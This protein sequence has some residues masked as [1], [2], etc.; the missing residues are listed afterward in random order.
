MRVT[1]LRV[2]GFLEMGKY[3]KIFFGIAWRAV[4]VTPMIMYCF[5][6][7]C[8]IIVPPVL[9]VITAVI[10]APPITRLFSEPA[11]SLFMPDEHF[12]RKQP[13]YSIPESKKVKGFY[14][15]A[16]AGY[17]KIAD[18]YP[19]ESKPYIEIISILAF[20]LNDMNRAT[21]VY[22][23]GL[24]KLT[25]SKQR[26]ALSTF[27]RHLKN[28][29]KGVTAEMRGPALLTKDG[30]RIKRAIEPFKPR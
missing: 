20:S 15:E 13:M 9:I 14:E 22:K 8:P 24:A 5:H 10:L 28:K 4:V 17:Q 30:R 25:S 21:D 16:I 7:S 6:K 2:R 27:F 29:V 26:Q 19:D 3:Q 18:E 11:G 12:D 1:L 23:K